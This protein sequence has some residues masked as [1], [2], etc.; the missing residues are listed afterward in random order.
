MDGGDVAIVVLLG[1]QVGDGMR[2]VDGGLASRRN[3]D[4]DRCRE[5]SRDVRAPRESAMSLERLSFGKCSPPSA[6]KALLPLKFSL[7]LLLVV[8]DFSFAEL[9]DDGHGE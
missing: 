7:A 2:R 6:G 1:D 3:R 9:V 5:E 8:L 4:L